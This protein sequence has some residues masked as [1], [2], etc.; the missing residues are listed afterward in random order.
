MKLQ[1]QDHRYPGGTCSWQPNHRGVCGL[2][3]AAASRQQKSYS[4]HL[5]VSYVCNNSIYAWEILPGSALDLL[6][7]TTVDYADPMKRAATYLLAWSASL[8]AQEQCAAQP[9]VNQDVMEAAPAF[10]DH[11]PAAMPSDLTSSNAS[12]QASS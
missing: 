6:H 9:R 3:T 4:E 5:G 2:G 12:W 7:A 11:F 10:M 1:S 8:E